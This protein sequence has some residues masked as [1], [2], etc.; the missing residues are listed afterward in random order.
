MSPLLISCLIYLYPNAHLGA[1]ILVSDFSTADPFYSPEL[2]LNTSLTLAKYLGCASDTSTVLSDA[3]A[4]CVQGIPAGNLALAAYDLGISWDI[5]VDGDY[6]LNDIASSIRDGVYAR[7]P[8]LW[9][10]TECDFCYFLPSTLS[11]AAP[12]SAYVQTLPLYFNQTQVAKI[13]NDTTLYPYETAPGEGGMSGAVLTLAQLLT[14]WVVLCP[15]T[16]LAALES[17]TTNPGNA[18]HAVFAVGLGSPLTPNPGMCHGRVCHADELYW[19]FGTAETDGLYQPLTVK[20]VGVTRQVMKRWTEMAWTGSPNYVGVE[21]VWEGYGGGNEVVVN[22]TESVRR[23]YRVT[24]CDF[25]AKELGLVYG[26]GT[27]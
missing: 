6:I 19:I 4:T 25:V 22:V 7:V 23:G 8:T 13:L 11:P 15:S 14:D 26:Y 2:A 27:Y 10:T 21:V 1:A 18:Y 9:S 3:D 5:V 16:Y 12:P 20:Q 17:N 24:E